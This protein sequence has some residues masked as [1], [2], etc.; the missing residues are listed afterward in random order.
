MP[1]RTTPKQHKSERLFAFR[2]NVNDQALFFLSLDFVC[3]P[4]RGRCSATVH[5]PRSNSKTNQP[6]QRGWFL[7]LWLRSGGW[8]L[9]N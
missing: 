2:S 9:Q 3:R 5:H 6:L 4:I 7:Q 8:Y 1:Q